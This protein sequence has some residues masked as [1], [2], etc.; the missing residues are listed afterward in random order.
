DSDRSDEACGKTGYYT[1]DYGSTVTYTVTI[2][3]N[4]GD[5]S[6]FPRIYFNDG[7][8]KKKLLTIE[9]W[10][11]GTWS[12]ME[13]AFYG[14]SN[15]TVQAADAPDLSGVTNM[16]RMFQDASAFNQDIGSWDTSSVTKMIAMFQNAVAFDQDIGSW[17]TSSVTQMDAMFTGVTLSTENY[18]ALLTG[19][20]AQTLQ[21]GVSFDGGNSF[22]CD[23]ETARESMISSHGWTIDDG[24]ND[25]S[26]AFGSWSFEEGS[27]TTT[28]DKTGHSNDGTLNGGIVWSTDTESGSGYAL[29]FD[30]GN[31]YVALP[32]IIDPVNGAFTAELWFNITNHTIRRSMLEQQNGTGSGYNWLGV[33]NNGQ[34]Y[35]FLGGSRLD[36]STVTVTPGQWQH[37]V[38]TYDGT[39]LSLYLD[40][41]LVNSEARTMESSDGDFLLG[42]N[43]NLN[44]NHF[45]GNL[46]DVKIY[47]EALS[48]AE[49]SV[50][51]AG[52]SPL[53]GT[54]TGG[55]PSAGIIALL[56]LVA[57]GL[58]L[59]AWKRPWRRRYQ[60]G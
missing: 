27:G 29:E 37:A 28:A 39:T 41:V 58:G 8:D 34:L 56:L 52:G 54:A 21:S 36:S 25:C 14:C 20:N 23:G 3:D 24:G 1:C 50:L 15:L 11:T 53:A 22:Y 17:D 5:G 12:S 60:S 9:Q 19:W 2:K 43:K 42:I 10:G 26:F 6:G 4:N 48:A 57:A 31:D 32:H 44:G 49:V 16:S 59:L 55:L 45:K 46:D 47:D 30:G 51:Y 35:T 18:D 7:G 40:G 33:Q 13:K 38:V